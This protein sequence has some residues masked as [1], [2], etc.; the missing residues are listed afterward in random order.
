[1]TARQINC[2]P[3]QP[4]T[5]VIANTPNA[6]LSLSIAKKQISFALGFLL[7]GG[8]KWECVTAENCFVFKLWDKKY[9]FKNKIYTRRKVDEQ[10]FRL[11]CDI[12]QWRPW[13][14]EE[15][16][17]LLFIRGSI[18]VIREQPLTTLA[19]GCVMK[20]SFYQYQ[21]QSLTQV[22]EGAGFFIRENFS[23]LTFAS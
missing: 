21:I 3:N 9:D 8:Q 22:L 14:R 15:I 11:M 6:N 16:V 20:N 17:F 18:L 12:W 10:L 23:S 2:S 1:M 4:L 19:Y 5:K 7:R 13:L